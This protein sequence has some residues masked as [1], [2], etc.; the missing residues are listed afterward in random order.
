MN[1]KALKGMIDSLVQTYKCPECSH[2]VQDNN[3]DVIGAAGSTINIDIE[4]PNCKKHSMIKSEIL[5]MDLTNMNFS[6][7]KIGQIKN[8]LE[9]LKGNISGTI[10][11]NGS[12]ESIKD[13]EIINL[14]TDL[15]KRNLDVSDLLG[16]SEK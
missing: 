5:S 2:D 15:K 8:V 12:I 6:S 3:V 13:E 11:Q 9:G 4:C 10:I 14:N 7:D 16:G 1:F